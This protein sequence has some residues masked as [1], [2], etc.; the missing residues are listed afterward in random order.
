MR[1]A[2]LTPENAARF[3]EQGVVDVYHLR[4]PYPPAMFDLLADLLP[5]ESRSV[6]DVGTGTGDLARR[7]INFAD[8][9]DAVD[10][11]LPMLIRAKTLPGGDHPNINWIHARLEEA[12]LNPPYDLIMGGDS[13]HW[14]DWDVAFPRFHDL[15]APTGWLAMVGR[16][17]TP[18]LWQ[19]ELHALIVRYSILQNFEA[20][21][22]VNKV[23]E[24]GYF[25]QAGQQETAPVIGRQSVEDYILSWHS[26]SSLARDSMLPEDRIAFD[27]QLREIVT[28]YAEEGLLTLY[29][30]G[31]VTWGKPL[32]QPP[33]VKTPGY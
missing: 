22:L 33:G 24:L 3:Q 29:T 19:D 2:H 13:I 30:I 16:S 26:R 8:H 6:L 31:K 4:L 12:E 14:F 21:S 10:A 11:S 18:P 5:G 23:I 20:Y 15:L 9:I 1:P 27:N 25:Q 32:K 7:M 28:P 17:E